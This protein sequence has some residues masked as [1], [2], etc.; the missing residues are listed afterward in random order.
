MVTEAQ[1]IKHLAAP[2]PDHPIVPVATEFHTPTEEM[3]CLN[4]TIPQHVNDHGDKLEDEG[5]DGKVDTLGG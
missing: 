2:H 1:H 4:A 3:V 5:G